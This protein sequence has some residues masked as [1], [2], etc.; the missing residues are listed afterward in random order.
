MVVIEST[1]IFTETKPQKYHQDLGPG[2]S[3]G[4]NLSSIMEPTRGTFMGTKPHNA[5]R[6]DPGMDP[7]QGWNLVAVSMV[8]SLHSLCP[9]SSSHEGSA[10]P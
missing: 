10:E 1:Q 3:L 5:T 9:W 7:S 4:P 6:R 8:P 2:P